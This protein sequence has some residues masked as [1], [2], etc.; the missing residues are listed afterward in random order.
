MPID[1]ISNVC[2]A[3]R[4]GSIRIMEVEAALLILQCH[5]RGVIMEVA[6]ANSLDHRT[7]VRARRR[8]SVLEVQLTINSVI[9]QKFYWITLTLV[10]N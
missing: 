9:N 3:K 8:R 1:M 10:K 2:L 6:V 7:K 5:F 4:T